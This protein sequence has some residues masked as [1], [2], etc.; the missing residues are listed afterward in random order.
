V[1]L[2]VDQLTPT[3]G[4]ASYGQGQIVHDFCAPL[5][6]S[7]FTCRTTSLHAGFR[8]EGTVRLK[9]GA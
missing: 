2:D 5:L 4:R 3:E 6:L 1:I 9:R 8:L 7:L